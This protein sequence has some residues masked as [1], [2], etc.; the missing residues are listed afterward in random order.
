[1]NPEV[2]HHHDALKRDLATLPDLEAKLLQ[3]RRYRRE[4]ASAVEIDL[5][6]G[7]TP[8]EGAMA[9]LTFLADAILI[10]TYELAREE[11]SH[12]YGLPRCK[13]NDGNFVSSEFAIIGMGK[14]GGLELHLYSDLD[15][16]FV[17]SRNGETQGRKTLSNREYF[18]KLAQRIISYLTLPTRAGYAYKVDT[19]LRPSGNA[20]TL[21]TSLDSWITYFHE[22]AAPWEQQAMLKARLI[23]ASGDFNRS[24]HGLFRRLVFIKPFPEDLPQEIHRLRMRIEVELAKESSRRWHFKKGRGGLL[25]IEFVV[26]YLQLKLGKVFDNLPTPNTLDALNRIEQR[27]ILSTGECGTLRQAYVFYR[28]LEI[29]LEAEFD[30]KEGYLDPGH[31]KME[32][33]ALRLSFPSVP[34]LFNSLDE[35]RNQVRAIYLKTLKVQDS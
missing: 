21:V 10:A 1:M 27:G 32:A 2:R 4:Q 14:L 26:Q 19:E 29:Y 5:F 17:Y 35:M 28:M 12:L 20:G 30:F 13:D 16:I 6:S 34:E 23:H 33:L 9:R 3:L 7:K 22:H 18:A 24:F 25:D 15:L 8:L 11:L 31:E